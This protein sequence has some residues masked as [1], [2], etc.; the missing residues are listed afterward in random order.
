MS[1][2]YIYIYIYIQVARFIFSAFLGTNC[3]ITL[4][5]MHLN[6]DYV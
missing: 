3:I 2:I 5:T 1:Y 4:T 6:F